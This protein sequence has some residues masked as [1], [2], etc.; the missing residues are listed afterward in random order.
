ML[1]GLAAASAARGVC[2]LAPRVINTQPVTCPPSQPSPARREGWEGVKWR[3]AVLRTSC[4]FDHQEIG[5]GCALTQ[6]LRLTILFGSPPLFRA[7]SAVEFDDDQTL[8]LPAALELF[9]RAA[10]DHKSAAEFGDR[11][12]DHLP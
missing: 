2:N 11:G 10:A 8:W 4:A 1:T 5:V 3:A 6:R 7:F 9:H 12:R